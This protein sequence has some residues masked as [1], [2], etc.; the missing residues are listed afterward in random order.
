[1]KI[2]LKQDKRTILQL[3]KTSSVKKKIR[4]LDRLNGVNERDSINI[5]LKILEDQSWA[6]REKAARKIIGYGSRVVPRL[7]HLLKRGYWY[8]RAAACLALGEIANQR[9]LKVIIVLLI[10]DD[11]P[12][13]QK[14]ATCALV[15]ILRQH[16]TVYKDTVQ[17][18]NIKTEDHNQLCSLV[19]KID[20][21]TAA[22]LHNVP[23][24]E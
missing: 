2:R 4:I 16:P 8:T 17:A 7:E 12:T 23:I 1:M 11:N 3:L 15:K 6:L 18:L 24:E 21:E 9:S 19:Q 20:P 22:M 10:H 5:L 13:V 14:E